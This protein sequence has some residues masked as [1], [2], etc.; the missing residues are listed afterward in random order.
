[1]TLLAA[2]REITDYQ[3]T[4]SLPNGLTGVVPLPVAHETLAQQLADLADRDDGEEEGVSDAD[5]PAARRTPEPQWREKR[6]CCTYSHEVQM[7]FCAAKPLFQLSDE[8]STLEELF[9]VDQ[10]VAC[11]VM[12]LEHRGTKSYVELSLLPADVNKNVDEDSI[13]QGT[14]L[15]VQWPLDRPAL[16]VA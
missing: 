9:C 7:S 2:V 8:I 11:A 3:L 14:I 12:K 5:S 15:Q 6:P 4:L 1:M 10:L 13:P 16:S